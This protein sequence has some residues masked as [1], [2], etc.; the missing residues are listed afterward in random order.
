MPE[1]EAHVV[2]DLQDIIRVFEALDDN[3]QLIQETQARIERRIRN[4]IQ[5]RDRIDDARKGNVLASMKAV[6][7]ANLPDHASVQ[8]RHGFLNTDLPLGPEHL[9]QQARKHGP[10][11]RDA[12][13]NPQPDPAEEAYEQALEA[14][15]ARA[16]ITGQKLAAYAEAMLGDRD[17]VRG[18]ELHPASLDDF[19][20]FER[21]SE[22]HVAFDGTFADRY[23]VEFTGERR[24]NVWLTFPDFILRRR[25]GEGMGTG[26]R[27][28]SDGAP[29]QPST[30]VAADRD[31]HRWN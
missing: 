23:E 19:F 22:I 6:A 1:G 21:L 26:F 11:E 16:Q 3:M 31:E 2:Q 27:N 29:A 9:Y 14:F 25:G 12:I 5:F 20:A 24:Q 4:A 8:V 18:S 30:A 17:W 7:Q 28:R 10:A 13:R 15:Q